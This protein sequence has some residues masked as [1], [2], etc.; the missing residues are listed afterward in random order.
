MTLTSSK[1]PALGMAAPD[2]KLPDTKGKIVSL[3]DFKDHQ[4]LLVIFMCNHC[5][6]VKHVLDKMVELIKKYQEKGVAV[7]GINSNDIINFPQDSPERMAEVAEEK[8]FTFSYLL[9]ESQETAKAYHATCTPDFF[10][11]DEQRKLVYRGQLDDSRPETDIPVTGSDLTS[12]INAVLGGNDANPHQKPSMG[13]NIK[14]KSG[15]E[16]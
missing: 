5:P 16:P 14:W 8:R 3:D 1:M 11:F 12:A 15:N 2:F 6:Y 13:C 7:V 4:L 9:D 10:L